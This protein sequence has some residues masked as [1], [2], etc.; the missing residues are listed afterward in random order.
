MKVLFLT[1]N[2]TTIGGIERVI[3]VLS[4]HFVT[5]LSYEVQISSLYDYGTNTTPAFS[6][7]SNIQ[8]K[9]HKLFLKQPKSVFEKVYQNFKQYKAI[10]RIINEE[11][12]DCIITTHPHISVPVLLCKKELK[13]PSIVTEHA[14]YN[15]CTKF[16]NFFRRL[17]YRRADKLVVLTETNKRK[18]HFISNDKLK[19][20][21]NP[22]SFSV[23]KRKKSSERKIIAVGRL[24]YEKG[25]DRIIDIFSSIENDCPNWTMDIIGDGS[26]REH[27]IKKIKEKNLN[28]KIEIKSFNPHIIDN[29][30]ESSICVIPSR[31]EAFS[32]VLVEAMSCGLACIIYN[33]PGPSEIISNGIDG[34]LV[35]ENDNESFAKELLKLIKNDE[36]R[37]YYG[38]NSVKKVSRYSIEYIVKEWS[39]LFSSLEL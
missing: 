27:L 23:G 10:K 4:N 18:Y 28:H 30:L 9:F 3:S 13:G 32:M 25:F 31:S 22:L 19:V 17:T 33:L 8:L 26:Q 5:D 24:E 35:S 16:W 21:P 20:I 12:Y 2:I 39:H 38:I 7:N 11:Q 34:S 37:D 36:L 6:L 15:N 29:Y 1:S 14:D